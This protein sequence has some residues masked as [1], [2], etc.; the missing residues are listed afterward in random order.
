V[1][2]Y[3]ATSKLAPANRLRNCPL[4]ELWFIALFCG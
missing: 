2:S 1:I 3:P 4:V